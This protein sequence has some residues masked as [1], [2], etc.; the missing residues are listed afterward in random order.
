M[1]HFYHSDRIET[2]D[3]RQWPYLIVRA[4]RTRRNAGSTLRPNLNEEVARLSRRARKLAGSLV[5]RQTNRAGVGP[6]KHPKLIGV[7][8]P[9]A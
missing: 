8:V 7:T 3:P 6:A 9:T 1:G 2:V 5:Q 4:K